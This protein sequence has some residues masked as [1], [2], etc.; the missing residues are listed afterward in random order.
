V[1]RAHDLVADLVGGLFVKVSSPCL[2]S[3][4]V[5]VRCVARRDDSGRLWFV[6][7]Q[8]RPLASVEDIPGALVAVKG[9]MA[10]RR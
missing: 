7:P 1:L 8:D 3:R 5:R 6:G 2:P 4:A 10:V 9:L